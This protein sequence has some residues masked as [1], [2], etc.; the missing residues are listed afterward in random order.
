[1]MELSLLRPARPSQWRKLYRLYRS[2]FPAAERKPFWIIMKMFRKGKTDVWCIER[3]GKFVGL[4]AT[5]NGE[6]LIL[7]DYFAVDPACR[8][9]GIGSA[10]L[11]KLL[12]IYAGKGLFVEI[13]STGG[14]A[15]NREERERRK[16]FYLR[17]GLQRLNVTATVFGVRMELLGRGCQM[18]FERYR[19]FYRDNYSGWAA[20]RILP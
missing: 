4:A 3:D 18:D 10:A 2:A 14:T 11:G 13:E 16:R 1:M 15:P 9:A 19:A 8:G 5:I 20:E 6:E 7:L 12:E 17:C